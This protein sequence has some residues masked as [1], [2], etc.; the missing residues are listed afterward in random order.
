L[1]K[2]STIDFDEVRM[3]SAMTHFIGSSHGRRDGRNPK[4]PLRNPEEILRSKE[5][6]QL[7]RSTVPSGEFFQS[8]K[9]DFACRIANQFS[10]IEKERILGR[11]P[12]IGDGNQSLQECTSKHGSFEWKTH[13]QRENGF[14]P[15]S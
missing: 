5:L 3:L 9:A 15:F 11:L 7:L 12:E 2:A 8:V 10:P 4:L 13:A 6:N 1:A 14:F